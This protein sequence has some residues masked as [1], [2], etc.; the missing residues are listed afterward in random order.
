MNNENAWDLIVEA[1]AVEGPVNRVS[2][3]LDKM[4][5]E[6]LPKPSKFV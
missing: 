3:K 1:D 5:L 4:K 2:M 6:E